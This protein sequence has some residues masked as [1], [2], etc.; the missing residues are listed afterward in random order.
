MKCP[1]CGKRICND[2]ANGKA[3]MLSYHIKMNHSKIWEGTLNQTLKK[4]PPLE[5]P[6]KMC[7]LC[8]EP[9]EDLEKHLFEEH[10]ISGIEDYS[11]FYTLV[12]SL[13]LFQ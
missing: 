5:K 4:H 9:V 11:R 8:E 2:E 13:E 3:G 6:L 7:N 10:G 1:Y 12:Y